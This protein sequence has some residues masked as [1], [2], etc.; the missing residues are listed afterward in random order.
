MISLISGLLSMI[1]KNK[2]LMIPLLQEYMES[3]T[4]FGCTNRKVGCHSHCEKYKKWKEEYTRKQELKKSGERYYS[5]YFYH[6]GKRYA[7]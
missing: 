3:N 6:K 2:R 5:D 7:R 4:C 1:F